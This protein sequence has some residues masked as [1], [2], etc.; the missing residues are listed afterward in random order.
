MRVLVQ[1]EEEWRAVLDE[2]DSAAAKE[3]SRAAVEALAFVAAAGEEEEMEVEVEAEKEEALVVGAAAMAICSCA[4]ASSLYDRLVALRK[5][6]FLFSIIVCAIIAAATGGHD[7]RP[8]RTGQPM[9]A[10]LRKSTGRPT[11]SR[12]CYLLSGRPT[13]SRRCF[14]LTGRHT[15]S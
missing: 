3:A 6:F 1:E 12:R 14:L 2:A 11:S 4:Q 13:P 8:L 10:V 9:R 15:R 7:M 5:L